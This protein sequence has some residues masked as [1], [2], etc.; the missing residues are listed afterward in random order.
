MTS[1]EDS[2][3]QEQDTSQLHSETVDGYTYL[4]LDRRKTSSKYAREFIA[5]DGQEPAKKKKRAW[6][7]L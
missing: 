4:R 2:T 6:Y 5:R 3:N 7:E 1:A